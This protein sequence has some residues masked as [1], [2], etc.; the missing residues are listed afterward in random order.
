MLEED[1]QFDGAASVDP[2][3][4][5]A[6]GILEQSGTI[7]RCKKCFNIIGVNSPDD[8]Y[9]RFN[10]LFSGKSPSVTLFKTRREGTDAIQQV[11]KVMQDYDDCCVCD[12]PINP[13]K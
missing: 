3:L 9:K 12:S 2:I 13:F 6:Q 11:H 4:A 10:T 8:A 7:E 5:S 1:F